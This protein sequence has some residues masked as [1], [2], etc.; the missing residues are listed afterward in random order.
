MLNHTLVFKLE[1]IQAYLN[2]EGGPKILSK[3][4]KINHVTIRLW[5]ENYRLH[6]VDGLKVKTSKQVY[7]PGFKFRAVQMI[8]N[9]TSLHEVRRQLDISGRSILRN[10]L[11]QYKEHGKQGLMPK[12]K[13]LP[14]KMKKPLKSEMGDV[15]EDHK[16]TKE[17][18]L[19]E[20]AYLRAEVAYLKK[21][22]ALI[23]QQKIKP[24]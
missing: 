14:R 15:Q 23:Q 24:Q 3:K 8:L 17:E 9:G 12:P 18:L 4:F 5:I 19:D 20:I 13:G 11:H 10:W 22:R 21:R 16:K 7:S 2:D 6:G 1:I